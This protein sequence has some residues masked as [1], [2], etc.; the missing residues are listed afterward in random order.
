MNM[1]IYTSVCV[2][3]CVCRGLLRSFLKKTQKIVLLFPFL[4]MTYRADRMAG[5]PAAILSQEVEE[6]S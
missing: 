5:I 1:Y 6:T 3:V 2:C 4:L